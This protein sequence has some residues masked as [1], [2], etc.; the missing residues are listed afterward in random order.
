MNPKGSKV[1]RKAGVH[2]VV[3]GGSLSGLFAARVL[4]DHF[5]RVTVVDRDRF[6]DHAVQRKGVPQSHHIHVLLARGAR[7][8]EQFF[9]SI[10]DDLT[11]VGAHALEW[12]YDNLLYTLGGWMPKV[13][14]GYVS[15]MCSRE[16]REFVVRQRV[17]ALGNVRFLEERDAVGLQADDAKTKVIG[18]RTRLRGHAVGSEADGDGVMRVDLVVDASGRSSRAPEWLQELGYVPP[19]ETNVNSFLG[20]ASRHYAPPPDFQAGWKALTLRGAPP[21]ANRGGSVYPIEGDRWL[22]TLAGAGR[23]YPPLDDAGFLEFARTLGQ[24]PLMYEALH[25]AT[26]LEPAVGYQR[27]DNR[28]RHYERLERQPENFVLVGDAA[29]AFNPVYGQGMTI[30]A[31]DALALDECLRDAANTGSL[32]GMARRFQRAMA[33]GLAAPWLMATSEDFRVPQTEGAKP[34]RATRVMHRYMDRVTMAASKNANV[35]RAFVDV[36]QLIKPPSALFS[37]AIVAQVLLQEGSRSAL[38]MST[39]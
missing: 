11:A 31:I 26:P 17:A 21:Y 5:G 35:F 27:T 20:Y 34:G 6:P 15:H 2:A 18:V 3:I 4:S 36:T 25:E 12:G 16:L 9:P 30:A 32:A 29:C 39:K 19:A 14:T 13:R 23:D 22:V 37:P 10:G 28:W 7:L 38:T 33:K 1:N 8:Y 24:P